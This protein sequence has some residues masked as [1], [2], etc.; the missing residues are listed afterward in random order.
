MFKRLLAMILILLMFSTRLTV[1]A[2]KEPWENSEELTEDIEL[3]TRCYDNGNRQAE[4]YLTYHPGGEV[5]P[6]IWFGEKLSDRLTFAEAAAQI[7][8][9]GKRVVAGTNGDYFVLS[10]GQP[11]G[12]VISEGRLITTDEGNSSVGFLPDGSAFFGTTDIRMVMGIKG[13]NY[14]L[15][16]VNKP[17][18]RGG[19]FLFTGDYGTRTPAQARVRNLVLVP[20]QDLRVG[21]SVVLRV[22]SNFWSDG[23]IP[24]PEDRWILCVTEDSDEWRLNA[25]DSLEE[26]DTFSLEITAEDLRWSMCT[27]AG[28]S[29]YRLIADGEIVP[30]LDKADSSRAPRTAVGVR[31]DGTVILYTVDGRQS[32]HSVGLTLD[33][34]ARRLSELGCVNAGAMDGGGSTTLYAQSSGTED[35]ALRNHPSDGKERAVSTFLFLVTE[36]EGSGEGKTLSVRTDAAAV[37]CGG[38]AVFSAGICDEKGTPVEGGIQ[39]SADSGTIDPDGVFTAPDHAEL[40]EIRAESRALSGSVCIPVIETPDSLRLLS[41][42]TNQEIFLLEPEPEETVDL[43][44]DASW[45]M[46]KISA[47]DKDFHWECTGNAGTID[48][49]GLFTASRYGGEGT[50]TVSAGERSLTVR[51]TVRM[52]FT[53][54]QPFEQIPSGSDCGLYWSTETNMDR[55]RFGQGSLRLDYDP[56]NGGGVCP[57][58]WNEE[59][60]AQ[61]LYL[62]VFGNGSENALYAMRKEGEV[63]LTALNKRGWTLVA[64]D[65]AFTG[66]TGIQIRGSEADTIWLDQVVLSNSPIPDLEP[67]HIVLAVDG[68]TIKASIRDEAD[69]FPE[70]SQVL[71]T[72]D[73]EAITFRYDENNGELRAEGASDETLQ[74]L[75]LC[76]WDRSGNYTQVSAYLD[77]G[78]DAPFPDMDG[79]WA[80][81]Y[82]GYLFRRGITKGRA[83]EDGFLFD[84]N[85]PVTRA[86]FAVFLTRWL[87]LSPIEGEIPEFADAEDIPAWAKDSVY[88]A[89]SHG[90]IQGSLEGDKLFFRPSASLTRAQAATILGRTCPAGSPYADLVFPDECDIPSWAAPYISR[91][92]YLGVINGFDDGTFR[93]DGT[94]TRAQAAKL[95]AEMS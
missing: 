14:R 69:G 95:L 66:I 43:T 85:A 54:V 70:Q 44:A 39:W 15:S 13:E 49:H 83:V 73:G 27:Y 82:A 4:H 65:T 28:G 8:A 20:D 23:G 90:L 58:S 80:E 51:V 84:P 50:I 87:S 92:V 33:E 89:S 74:H 21:G 11:V 48:P 46:V 40:A 3:N 34:A 5:F 53:C 93:P 38:S 71:L 36:G 55:I 57:V 6:V 9:D 22:E 47:E 10:T 61:Y 78:T 60:E 62:W 41:E 29:L 18:R 67:P 59:G 81:A 42:S 64:L 45:G 63:L 19:F 35:A 79:H 77:G 86:E 68:D 7:E 26:G 30:D 56:E 12:L 75:I 16:G 31:E 72:L 32:D 1:L 94:L 2:Q 88:A 76:A 91:L 17:V 24:I 25:M 37:L 52:R